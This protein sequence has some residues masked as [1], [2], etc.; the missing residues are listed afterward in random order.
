M[1]V[2]HLKFTNHING[3]RTGKFQG[4]PFPTYGG[5]R[6][7]GGYSDHFAVTAKFIIEK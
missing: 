1:S 7:L 6:Y 4:A 3:N 5:T 2:I